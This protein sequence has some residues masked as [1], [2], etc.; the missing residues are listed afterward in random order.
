MDLISNIIADYN[1][2]DNQRPIFWDKANI[3]VNKI[4]EIVKDKNR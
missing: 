2:P 4:S 3:I 1:I